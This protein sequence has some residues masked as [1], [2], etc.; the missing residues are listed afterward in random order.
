MSTTLLP[1]PTREEVIDAVLKANPH[2]KLGEDFTHPIM[3]IADGKPSPDGKVVLATSFMVNLPLTAD[4]FAGI[5]GG[6]DYFHFL[7]FGD[8]HFPNPNIKVGDVVKGIDPISF[9]P[10]DKEFTQADMDM[11]NRFVVRFAFS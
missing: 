9:Q 6:T 11:W 7:G 8:Y 4:S 3:K 10:V 2:V 1:R 5:S